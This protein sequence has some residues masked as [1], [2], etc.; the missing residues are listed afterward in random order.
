M[1]ESISQESIQITG[2]PGA[3]AATRYVGA[4]AS[5]YPVSGSFLKGDYIVDQTGSIY[6]C[7][8]SG[9][10]GTWAQ[11]G[12]VFT[13]GTIGNTTVT[14]TL[15]VTGTTIVT[16]TGGAFSTNDDEIMTIMG[17]WI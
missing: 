15:T 10:P 4:T 14:G 2:L 13:G 12:A 11:T 17:A 6:I 9:S 1:A 7:T 16:Q 3:V 5:G 8:T